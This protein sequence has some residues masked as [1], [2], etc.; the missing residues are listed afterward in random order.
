MACR[1][2]IWTG[3]SERIFVS[4]QKGCAGR[5]KT[6][7]TAMQRAA[8]GTKNRDGWNQKRRCSDVKGMGK[9]RKAGGG[10]ACR[11]A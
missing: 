7:N 5:A 3:T 11:E 4:V 9:G 6:V 2:G 10:G 1:A 8:R